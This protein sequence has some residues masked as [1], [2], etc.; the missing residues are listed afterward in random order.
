MLVIRQF[1]ASRQS[2][3]LE[4]VTKRSMPEVVH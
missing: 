4:S 3:V 2:N 1:E